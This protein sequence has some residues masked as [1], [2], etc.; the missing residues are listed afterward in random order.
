MS[1]IVS[2]TTYTNVHSEVNRRWQLMSNGT[3][4]IHYY[5]VIYRNTNAQHAY[6]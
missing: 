2:C 6:L 5:C 3:T 4:V 1:Q